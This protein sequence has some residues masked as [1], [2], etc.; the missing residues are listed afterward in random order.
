MHHAFVSRLQYMIWNGGRS[1]TNGAKYVYHFST[2]AATRLTIYDLL[3]GVGITL[4]I[5]MASLSEQGPA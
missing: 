5:F 1:A 2:R 4:H 3:L